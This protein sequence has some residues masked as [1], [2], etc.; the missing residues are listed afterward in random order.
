MPGFLRL[1]LQTGMRTWLY[2]HWLQTV[3]KVYSY[4]K[5]EVYAFNAI[6][7]LRSDFRAVVSVATIKRD[8]FQSFIRKVSS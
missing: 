2:C 8:H 7:K 4:S 6:M 3:N 1:W 5:D